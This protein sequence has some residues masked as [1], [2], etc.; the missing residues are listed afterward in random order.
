M[1]LYE[2]L[3]VVIAAVKLIIDIVELIMTHK[4]SRLDSAK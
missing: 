1:S 2:V 4:K 3:M